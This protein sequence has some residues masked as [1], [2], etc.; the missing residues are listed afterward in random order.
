MLITA[1]V[2]GLLGSFHCAL[3]CGPLALAGCSSQRRTLGYFGG[4]ALVYTLSG[5]IF[6]SLGEHAQHRMPI[7]TFQSSVL[8]A[9]A[10]L[11]FVKGLRILVRRERLVRLRKQPPARA[12]LLVAIL[13][14]RGLA[15][16]L[17][18][19][20]LPCGL[21]AGGWALAAS[22]GHALSGALAMLV[23][24]LATLPSLAASLLVATRVRWRPS[25]NVA[26]VLWCALAL[27]IGLRPLFAHAMHG[28]H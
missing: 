14:R 17:A 3:M 19:G 5:A 2:F 8:L 23:F 22:A 28:G 10:L 18:T 24:S 4:R 27:W 12:S 6:G 16:G 20:F 9:V 21:L 15:L 25:P 7:G 11:A 13:P 26:G 1:F